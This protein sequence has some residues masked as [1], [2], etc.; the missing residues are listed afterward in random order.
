MLIQRVVTALVLLPLLLG[1]VW[2]APTAA[3]YGAFAAAGALI[4]W[5]W[6]G[7]MQGVARGGRIAYAA[8][9]LAVLVAAW[10]TP[11]RGPWLPWLLGLA[12]LW[13][14]GAPLL[15]RGF[16]DKLKQRP[17]GT[18]V[19]GALG[20]LLIASTILALAH[21]HAQAGGPLKLLFLLF[22]VFAADTGAFLAG[23][24]FGRHKLA[25]AISPGKTVEG[26]IGGLL[27]CAAWALT[28][29]TY[30]FAVDGGQLPWLLALSLL[31]AV[32]SIVGDLVESMFKRISGIKD[33]GHILPG[34]G[35]V[36]DRVDSILA[37]AP[38]MV[39]G[40]TLLGL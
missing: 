36:L 15:F 11:L 25:P 19:M 4:A 27:L 18:P 21:L 38:V 16:P 23:R 1:L 31:T 12:C 20:L 29:G 3:V 26:A 22:L 13:W 10:W 37:A 39:L 28:A 24:N 7:L 34:H 35:G 6:S 5:E 40:L 8:G 30:V 9:V 32:A 33:S 14:L 2:Y 17:L